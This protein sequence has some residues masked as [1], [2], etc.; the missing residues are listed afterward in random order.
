[1]LQNYWWISGILA[2]SVFLYWR[3]RKSRQE[4]RIE[5][6]G[7]GLYHRREEHIDYYSGRWI[8]LLTR[9]DH[10]GRKR[11]PVLSAFFLDT[12]EKCAYTVYKIPSGGYVQ[13]KNGRLAMVKI[14]PDIQL[15]NSAD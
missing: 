4:P 7:G 6:P 5:G 11:P 8:C 12:G 1:M 15:R 3:R 9:F 2:V 14:P 10:S 13:F